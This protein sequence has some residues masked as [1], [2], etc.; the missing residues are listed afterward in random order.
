M[1]GIFSLGARLVFA[2][3]MPLPLHKRRG[4]VN[5]RPSWRRSL[6]T[7]DLL[8]VCFLSNGNTRVYCATQE[9]VPRRRGTFEGC[10]FKRGAT[11]ASLSLAPSVVQ[12]APAA[13][14][15]RHAAFRALHAEKS[16]LA[17]TRTST[18]FVRFLKYFLLEDADKKPA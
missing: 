4:P 3:M 2:R 9:L 11:D 6:L 1:A 7:P 13:T 16:Q 8:S 17:A 18:F 5:N 15:V 10:D 14:L 12:L